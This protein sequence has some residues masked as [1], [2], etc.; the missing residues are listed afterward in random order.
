[1]AGR[2]L[3]ERCCGRRCLRLTGGVEAGIGIFAPGGSRFCV[4]NQIERR[5]ADIAA[6]DTRR[7]VFIGW[8]YFAPPGAKTST[9]SATVR[10]SFGWSAPTPTTRRSSSSPCSLRI[11][12]T[13]EYSHALEPSAGCLNDPSTRSGEY[14]ACWRRSAIAFGSNRR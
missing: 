6:F 1:Q 2:A 10:L 13:T 7:Q 9:D 3:R 5:H 14:V 4:S 8:G 12:T 11:E